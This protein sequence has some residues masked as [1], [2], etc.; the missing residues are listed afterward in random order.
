MKKAVKKIIASL[1]VVIVIILSGLITVTLSPHMLFAKKIEHQA[2]T[3]YTVLIL[4]LTKL[5]LK[6]DWMKLTH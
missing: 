5:I 4:T 1:T 6:T 3:I 2:F